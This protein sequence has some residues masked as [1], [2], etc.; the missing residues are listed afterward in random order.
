MSSFWLRYRSLKILTHSALTFGFMRT[1][2]R[3]APFSSFRLNSSISQSSSLL[4]SF[5]GSPLGATASA[6]LPSGAPA[7]LFY[8]SSFSSLR[9]FP[10]HFFF[11][12]F[13]SFLP[14]I[15]ELVFRSAALSALMNASTS[16]TGFIAMT[17]RYSKVLSSSVIERQ[18]SDSSSSKSLEPT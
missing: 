8:S 2:R 1:F 12:R 17:C 15:R 11:S 18:F 6:S 10:L 3:W 16:S 5:T 9:C 13:F 7:R 14:S 4:L